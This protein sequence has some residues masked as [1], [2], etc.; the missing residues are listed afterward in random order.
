[1]R[2]LAVGCS[3]DEGAW[4]QLALPPRGR[5]APSTRRGNMT[6]EGGRATTPIEKGR[7]SRSMARSAVPPARRAPPTVLP[8][9]RAGFHT[10][11]VCG[12]GPGKKERPHSCSPYKNAYFRT[13]IAAEEPSGRLAC[14]RFGSGRWYPRRPA[15]RA[16]SKH[17]RRRQESKAREAPPIL[18]ALVCG[19]CLWRAMVCV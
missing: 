17:E 15:S 1:M 2:C 3:H 7:R 19:V 9:P 18:R 5:S 11:N 8:P 6:R 10:S 14:G 4:R 12:I 13:F 16:R